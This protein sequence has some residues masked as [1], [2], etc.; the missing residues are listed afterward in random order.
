MVKSWFH[1]QSGHL[2]VIFDSTEH[3]TLVSSI[4]LPG[5]PYL[6]VMTTTQNLHV[7][8]MVALVALEALEAPEVAD[9]KVLVV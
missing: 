4:F 3:R 9:L 6:D 1:G 5:A 7:Q 2:L 8:E